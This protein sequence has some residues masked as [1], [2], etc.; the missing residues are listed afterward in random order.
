MTVKI[1]ERET[2]R[3]GPHVFDPVQVTISKS[4]SI[5]RNPPAPGDFV[6][7]TRCKVCHMPENHPLHI[8]TA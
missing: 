4:G 6:E 2:P 5:R 3:L 7:V 8:V 1:I